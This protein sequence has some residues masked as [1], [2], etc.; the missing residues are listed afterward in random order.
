MKRKKSARVS[1]ANISPI[2][3]SVHFVLFLILALV[4]VVIVGYVMQ[5]TAIATRARLLC[6]QSQT[7]PKDLISELSRRCADGVE[8]VT[9]SNG[10]NVWVCRKIPKVIGSP[11]NPIGSPRLLPKPP[12][13]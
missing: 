9:D 8:Y 7:D 10:C 13:K 5:Q 12:Q 4:L 11:K 1:I 6:P 2:N 3:P